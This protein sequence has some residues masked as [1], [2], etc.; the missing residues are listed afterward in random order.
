[1]NN[2]DFSADT[3]DEFRNRLIPLLN[4]IVPQRGAGRTKTHTEIYCISRLL[5]SLPVESLSLPIRLLKRERPD[6]ELHL[7]NETIGIEHTEGIAQ[8]AAHK[9]VLRTK[10]Y[11][12]EIF[13]VERSF[14]E[15]PRKCKDQLINELEHN[16]LHPP[17]DG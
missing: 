8:N 2:I 10:G 9:N 6:F 1:M 11:G 17:L 4:T 15:E 16:R 7:A 13:F 3:R 12:S 14:I 5:N